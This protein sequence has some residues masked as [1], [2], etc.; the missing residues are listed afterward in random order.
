[1]AKAK[2][3]G[4]GSDDD[5]VFTTSLVDDDGA[6][7]IITVP[8]LAKAEINEFKMQLLRETAPV[9]AIGYALRA[10]LGPDA[11]EVITQLAELS[12]SESKQFQDQ[13]S[14]HS[15]VSQGES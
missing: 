1:M 7:V 13:W 15:G 3:K 14:E 4:R 8:S 2:L 6:P 12:P 10:S 11:D 5:F 9:K